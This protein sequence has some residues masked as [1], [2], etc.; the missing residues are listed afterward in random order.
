M[1][2]RWAVIALLT[3]GWVGSAAAA[4]TPEG[5]PKPVPSSLKAAKD[6]AEARKTSETREEGA[7]PE[8]SGIEV[9][10]RELHE[11]LLKQAQELEAQWRRIREQQQRMEELEARLRV[12][13]AGGESAG[14]SN[15]RPAAMA[16]M[17]AVPDSSSATQQYPAES[18]KKPPLSFKIGTADFTPGGFLD[19][20]TIFRSRNLGSGIGT[21]FGSI[22]FSNTLPQ[23]ALPETRLTAQNSRLSLQVNAKAGAQDV[24]GY[25]ET[26]FLGFQPPNANTTSNSNSL[27]VRLY[28]VNIRRNKWE[29]LAGQA[30]S[31]MTPNRVGL[32]PV[33]SDV[34]YTQDMDTNYQVGLTWAR[35]TAFRVIYHASENLAFGVSLEN[36]QQLVPSSVV[37]PSSS[38]TSQF[39]N[40]S[41]STSSSSSGTNPATPNLHPDII[42]KLAFD[43][44]IGTR[45]MH[46]EAAGLL[47][48]FK[49]FNP[50]TTPATTDELH[51]EAGGG[52]INLNLEIFRNFHLIANSFYSYGG[53]RY[54]FGLGPDVIVQPNGLLSGVHSGSGIGGF[55]WQATSHSLLYGYYGG[56]YFQRNFGFAPASATSSCAGVSSTTCVGFGFPGSSNAANR[57]I[58]E[59]T[60]G[61]IQT[62]WKNPNYGAL[63]IITQA[64]YLT[65]S[66]WSVAPGTPKNAHLGMGYVDLRYVLP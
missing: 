5:R 52:S 43:G 36:P 47:R 45:A 16:T 46:V 40:G 60:F 63:Q 23:G 51:V 26:D 22:P 59:G 50:L 30:W 49:I 1:L 35:Q 4:D 66:P 48:S 31:W 62:L 56:A 33:P 12:V 19:F 14:E 7:R 58:Q 17:A 61:L 39:D 32:S 42:L 25:V 24:T 55:E 29:F 18:E 34:F 54:I 2:L 9:E 8:S 6:S 10:L 21:S 3:L 38:F 15:P 13:R 41:G 53:G 65:R 28:W 44:H 20:T 64:S 11:M 57:T 37:F 27:R